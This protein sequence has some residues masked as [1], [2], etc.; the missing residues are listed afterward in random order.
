VLRTEWGKTLRTASNHHPNNLVVVHALDSCRSW[1]TS[2]PMTGECDDGVWWDQTLADLGDSYGRVCILGDSMGGT[3]ALRYAQHASK[4]GGTVVSFV[5]QVN[6]NDFIYQERN[7]LTVERKDR[8][9]HDIQQA[10]LT[11]SARV[12]VHVG[13]DVDDLQQLTYLEEAVSEHA[14]LGLLVDD[15]L[16]RD[17]M[18]TSRA[19]G[20]HR[21]RVVKH[22]VEGHAIGTQLKQQGFLQEIV[23]GDLFG[24]GS[25]AD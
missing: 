22:D 2:N 3:A 14:A 5:P 6:L 11:T 13:R 23:L 25:W 4:D 1:Y 15:P 18:Q 12:V 17:G 21:L 10:V 19:V 24:S 9:C 16:P 7:E 8:L 20:N